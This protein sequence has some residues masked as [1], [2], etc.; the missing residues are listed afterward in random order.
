MI[1]AGRKDTLTGLYI[2]ENDDSSSSSHLID[3]D[4]PKVADVVIANGIGS[5]E[6]Y[7][8]VPPDVV[9]ERF[10]N[11]V[12]Q[13]IIH[14]L[15]GNNREEPDMIE[16]NN[17]SFYHTTHCR[18]LKSLLFVASFCQELETVT[19]SIHDGTSLTLHCW[20]PAIGNCKSF[21]WIVKREK[22]VVGTIRMAMLEVASNGP[23]STA[24]ASRFGKNLIHW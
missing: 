19:V 4:L 8:T 23:E 13:Q 5:N 10:L 22:N 14:P 16:T 11:M 18:D 1:R 3:A 21:V 17:K 24:H 6:D 9:L 15:F 20:Q 2:D 12:H 7:L